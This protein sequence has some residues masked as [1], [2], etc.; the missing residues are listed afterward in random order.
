M[1]DDKWI[2]VDERL[3]EDGVFVLIYQPDRFTGSKY[4][5]GKLGWRNYPEPIGSIRAW[6]YGWMSPTDAKAA[7]FEGSSWQF[8]PAPPSK[9]KG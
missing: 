4:V 2:P 1:N 6:L 7:D 5:V 9:S 3:P 8:L